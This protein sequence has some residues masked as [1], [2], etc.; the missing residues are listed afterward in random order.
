MKC[1]GIENE[2]IMIMKICEENEMMKKEN[3]K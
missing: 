1:H 2:I 3:N